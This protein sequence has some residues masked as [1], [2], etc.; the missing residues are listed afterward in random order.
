MLSP[1]MFLRKS[2]MSAM[3]ETGRGAEEGGEGSGS[4]GIVNVGVCLLLL[5]SGLPLAIKLLG[6][7]SSCG[8]SSVSPMSLLLLSV[9][10]GG[11]AASLEN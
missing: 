3:K 11:E 8:S 2:F 4:S 9:P 1:S 5:V 10:Q 7:S 6:S